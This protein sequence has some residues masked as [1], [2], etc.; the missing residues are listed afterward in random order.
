MSQKNE[1][2]FTYETLYEILRR[3]K[4]KEELQ[5]IEEQFHQN[6]LAYLKE[7]QRLYD[8]TLKKDDLFSANER[9]ALQI[10]IKNIQKLLKDLY[11]KREQ[12]IIEMSINSVKINKNLIDTSALLSYEKELYEEITSTLEKYRKNILLSTLLLRQPIQ[13]IK[14]Q[15]NQIENTEENKEKSC[16]NKKEKKTESDEEKKTEE[17]IKKIIFKEDTEQFVGKNLEIYG[18]FQ[19]NT[20]ANIP[21]EI[22]NILIK[23]G[24]AEKI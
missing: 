13:E 16:E 5:E 1:I 10:Q 24:K 18:P 20:E 9:D 23:K 19:K 2:T 12:K 7:K 11:S 17:K 14:T 22:A 4:N 8:D 3:E 15:K 21:T 6:A